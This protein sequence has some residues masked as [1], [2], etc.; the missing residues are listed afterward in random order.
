[1]ITIK[2]VLDLAISQVGY[3][4]K[5]SPKDE[6]S[7]V[8]NAG[9]NN[10]TKY[11]RDLVKN[12][13]SPYAD[14]VSWCDEFCDWLFW[15]LGGKQAIM[16][17]LYGLSAYTPTS[18]GYFKNNNAW[19]IGKSP[20]PGYQ[21]FFKNSQRICHTGIVLKCE[22]GMVYT[23]E[24][25]T[26]S[27]KGVVANGG[28]VAQKS[29]SVSYARIAGY[30]IPKCARDQSSIVVPTA[31][32]VRKAHEKDV[33]QVQKYVNKNF[34]PELKK[35]GVLK[36]DLIVDGDY[37]KMTRQAILAKWKLELKNTFGSKLD[38]INSA[39]GPSCLKETLR[40]PLTNG[41]TGTFAVIAQLLLKA[42]G[43]YT[44]DITGIIDSDTCKAI[45]SFERAFNLIV[46]PENVVKVGQQ[47]WYRL[48]N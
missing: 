1:M 29:Y 10:F 28:C 38:P 20:K 46:D 6:D 14:G 41:S 26:S 23:I 35:A 4:E 12:V 36:G 32:Q 45:I 24:G 18:A 8:A 30:G 44:G 13:G 5:A 19:Y 39:F 16:E 21:I 48:F 11:G 43:F 33:K 3:L 42:K 17:N 47:V 37:G 25:N 31:S 40:C 7:M 15:K 34:I 2:Q 27:A 22:N 9:A